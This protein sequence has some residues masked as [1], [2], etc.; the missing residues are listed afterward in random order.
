MTGWCFCFIAVYRELNETKKLIGCASDGLYIRDIHRCNGIRDCPDGSDEEGCDNGTRGLF[1]FF[2][3]QNGPYWTNP[4]N[5]RHH[6]EKEDMFI[7]LFL[8]IKVL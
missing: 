2:F 4:Y 1:F 3:C 8:F 6:S 5:A 7:Y